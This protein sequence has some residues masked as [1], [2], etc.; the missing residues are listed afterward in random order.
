M[1]I[2]SIFPLIS[3][4]LL[5]SSCGGDDD[6]QTAAPPL[7][8]ETFV[9][10]G[11]DE[12]CAKLFSCCPNGQL[13]MADVTACEDLYGQMMLSNINEGIAQGMIDYN[14]FTAS[15]C[16]SE[17]QAFFSS[18]TCETFTAFM[19]SS[20]VTITSACGV[21]LRGTVSEGESC[22]FESDSGTTF[23]SD[24]YCAGN[25]ICAGGICM[26][27]LPEGGECNRGLSGADCSSGLY[28]VDG[29]CAAYVSAGGSCS[30]AQECESRQCSA[31][32]CV[33]DSLC[34]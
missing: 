2:L 3:V 29:V 7:E 4:F 5:L 10:A 21:T 19:N 14:E 12:A 31:G 22:E 13:G 34:P 30:S 26:Y 17:V 23:Q 9:Q 1:K 18:A 33:A 24:D 28:C 20:E 25:L 15:E 32:V 6:D 27:P 11:S 8:L 16:I